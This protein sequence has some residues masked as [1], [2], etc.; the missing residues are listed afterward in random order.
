[1][2]TFPKLL[3]SSIALA[4]MASAGA[5]TVLQSNVTVNLSSWT[6][7]GSDSMTIHNGS[8]S[9]SVLAGGFSGKLSNAGSYNNASFETYCIEITESFGLPSDDMSGYDIVKGSTYAGWAFNPATAGKIGQLM[10]YADTL[11]ANT[12]PADKFESA[13]LQLAIWEVIYEPAANGYNVT[14]NTF[15]ANG[16]TA[17]A[18]TFATTLLSGFSSTASLYNVDVV[19]KAGSQDFLVLTPVPEPEGYALAFA[20]LACIGLFGRKFRAAKKA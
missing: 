3:V 5:E 17:A 2:K 15:W 12:G 18:T 1:M 7:G 14:S 4:A 8:W 9:K 6:Y 20:G 19:R 10:T 16:Q 13:G 11:N